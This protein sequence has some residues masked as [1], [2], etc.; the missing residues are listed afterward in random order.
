MDALGRNPLLDE[1][2]Y[3]DIEFR[4]MIM[5]DL[6]GRRQRGVIGSPGLRHTLECARHRRAAD[7]IRTTQRTAAGRIKLSACGHKAQACDRRDRSPAQARSRA[8]R[9]PAGRFE[10]RSP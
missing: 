10:T 5:E 9:P 7:A 8:S 2:A 4:V 6:A 1:L 3:P